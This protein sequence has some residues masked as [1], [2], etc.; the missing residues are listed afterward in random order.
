[1]FVDAA[2]GTR[3]EEETEDNLAL[4]VRVTSVAEAE[5]ETE[6]DEQNTEVSAVASVAEAIEVGF[7]QA[8]VVLEEAPPIHR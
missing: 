3:A 6:V 2:V 4:E 8:E 5:A 7:F 1:M